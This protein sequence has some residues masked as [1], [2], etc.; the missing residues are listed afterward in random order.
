[1]WTARLD[2][3]PNESARNRPVLMVRDLDLQADRLPVYGSRAEVGKDSGSYWNFTT[4]TREVRLRRAAIAKTAPNPA[5]INKNDEGSGTPGGV[6]SS[7][8]TA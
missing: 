3:M 4:C 2:L 5:L 1:M 6:I 7:S 8:N